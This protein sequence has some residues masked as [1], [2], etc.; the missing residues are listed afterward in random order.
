M[1]YLQWLTNPF[2][3]NEG[4]FDIK[5]YGA[6][7]DGVTDDRLAIQTAIN[8]VPQS[9][10]LVGG[11]V[12][13]PPGRYVIGSPGLDIHNLTA[14]VLQG[15]F[16]DS[17]NESVG[18]SGYGVQLLCGANSMTLLNNVNT[19][20]VHQ[21]PRI[22]GVHFNSNDKTG[23]T[24]ASIKD[25]NHWTFD[26]CNFH[27]TSG[28]TGS[29][30]CLN[31]DMAND[32][33]YGF[34]THCTWVGDAISTGINVV[35][36]NGFTCHA[37]NFNFASGSVAVLINGNECDFVDCKWNFSVTAD[38]SH[39]TVQDGVNNRFIS[40]SF[41]DHAGTNYCV[42]VNNPITGFHPSRTLFLGT[43]STAAHVIKL[44]SNANLTAIIGMM[45]TGSPGDVS[46]ASHFAWQFGS[47][48]G[49]GNQIFKTGTGA[50]HG[51]NGAT[52]ITKPS[53]T[54]SKG[55]NAALTSLMTALAN[56]GLVTDSTS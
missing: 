12:Y 14:L 5:A 20:L 53:V 23:V 41:E 9:G 33:A 50:F 39:V 25:T 37:N 30:I 6:V 35:N 26:H 47:A 27:I 19:S 8:A 21:G 31:L 28:S 52:P 42:L 44:G 45:S 54:G 13:F 22:R 55:A 36:G 16:V 18:T 15:S 56:Y 48:D 17:F 10:A 32:T 51:F 3:N 49:S 43:S 7:G 29:S 40:C 24:L 2:T 46:D 34:L 4:V 38:G 1:S 11:T